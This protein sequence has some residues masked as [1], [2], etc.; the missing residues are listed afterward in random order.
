MNASPHAGR[1][2]LTIGLALLALAAGAPGAGAQELQ[3]EACGDA[4]A[5]CATV[6]APRDYARPNGRTLDIAVTRVK[7][8]E[9]QK[10]IGSL[11]FNLG[12]PGVPAAI[13]VERFGADLF[14]TLSDRFDIVGIDPRGTGDSEGAIDC[15]VDQEH[16]GAYSQPFTTPLD[17]DVNQLI[18]TD[19]RYIQRCLQ[20]NDAGVLPYVSTA[21]T[22][23]DMDRVRDA[24]GERQLS[25]LG[26]SYGT[27]LGATYASLFPN[28]YR[29][30]V[31]D[32]ALDA[33]RYIN[34]PL[35][36][37]REQTSGFERALGRFLAACEGDQIACSGFGGND[38][39]TAF[40]ELIEQADRQPLPTA[41]GRPVDGDDIRAGSVQSMY[42]KSAWGALG[43]ALA[44]AARGDGTLMRGITDRFYGRN[45]DGSYDPLLDRYY[46]ISALEQRYPKSV[47]VYL[48]AG[49]HSWGLFDHVFWNHGY[50]ELAWG[51][52][53]VDPRGVFRGPFRAVRSA[54]PALVI[55]T[56]YDP[57]TPYRGAVRLARDLGN[58]RLLTMRGDGHTAYDGQPPCIDAAVDAYLEDAIVPAT[59]TTCVQAVPFGAPARTAAPQGR[60]LPELRPHMRPLAPG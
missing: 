37:L 34:K 46:V 57:A 25:Y 17:L 38:P 32:G 33:D 19:Q 20:R 22:A 40:D 11:F 56:T 12:G 1:A 47:N 31:L 4:G 15:K 24:L 45:P 2:L 5:E 8:T 58:A 30:L 21:S 60:E 9:P 3:W 28:R 10:R 35:E 44:Q 51:L 26:F 43:R 41:Q 54:P 14:G 7:A 6:T 49:D 18:A 52:W 39:W 27:L 59:G 50:T 23:R 53:P 16:E 13:Y 42:S 48:N 29:A 36:S 55:G